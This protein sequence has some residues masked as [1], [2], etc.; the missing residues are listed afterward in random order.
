[1]IVYKLLMQIKIVTTAS[2]TQVLLR[3]FQPVYLFPLLSSDHVTKDSSSYVATQTAVCPFL[4]LGRSFSINN[5]N[6]L[7]F[8][9]LSSLYFLI[10]SSYYV[11][12]FFYSFNY[13]ITATRIPQATIRGFAHLSTTAVSINLVQ[14][15]LSLRIAVSATVTPVAVFKVFDRF[16][17]ISVRSLRLLR[18]FLRSAYSASQK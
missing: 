18:P 16:E 15:W 13:R 5:D 1:M 10:C 14:C 3:T 6:S 9:F 12:F 17:N 11:F 8:S 7:L 4:L 2:S